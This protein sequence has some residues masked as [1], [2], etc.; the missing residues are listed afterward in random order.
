M[1]DNTNRLASL[2][3]IREGSIVE[4]PQVARARDPLSAQLQC[5]IILSTE[6]LQTIHEGQLEIEINSAHLLT[7]RSKMLTSLLNAAVFYLKDKEVTPIQILE[8]VSSAPFTD[9]PKDQ[10]TQG[11]SP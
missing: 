7:D 4:L 10:D 11:P 2:N 8:L 9:P 1:A 5:A 6:E 3:E